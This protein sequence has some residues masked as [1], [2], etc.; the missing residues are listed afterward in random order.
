MGNEYIQGYARPT[1]LGV[2]RRHNEDSEDDEFETD[3]IAS[4][5][6]EQLTKSLDRMTETLTCLEQ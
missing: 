3:T 2:A 6:L 5:A 1:R 4:A